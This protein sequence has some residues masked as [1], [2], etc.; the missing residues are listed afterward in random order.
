MQRGWGDFMIEIVL[1]KIMG[2]KRLTQ[3]AVSEKTGIRP[4]AISD[5]W[6]GKTKSISLENMDKLCKGLDCTP[7]DLFKYVDDEEKEK[8]K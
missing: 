5:L 8:S 1:S 7:G 4:N 3:K 2:E 6:H